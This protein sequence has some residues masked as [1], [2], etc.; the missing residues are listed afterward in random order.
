MFK[1]QDKK[2]LLA[3][4][5]KGEDSM[6][7]FKE[8][9]VALA[10]GETSFE[11]EAVAHTLDGEKIDIALSLSVPPGYEDTLSKVFVSMIDIT[12]E[13]A[14]DH[15]KSEF[16]SLVSHQ[17]RDPLGAI[18]WALEVLISEDFGR[19]SEGQ[20]KYVDE[21]HQDADRMTDL[22]NAYLNVSR[23]ELGTL[24]VE[25]EILNLK[26]IAEETIDE[27]EGKISGKKLK[28]SKKFTGDM[29]YKSD[30]KLIGIIFQNLLSN[31]VKYTPEG[32]KVGLTVSV[33]RELKIV[34]SD[35][36]CGIPKRQQS[37]V[38]D[39]LFRAKNARKVDPDGTGLGI[40]LVK[41]IVDHL[42]GKISFK[43]EEG[44]GSVFE[45]RL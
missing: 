8:E 31:V 1:A 14:V 33:G 20:K 3:G 11:D 4:L 42:G 5:P 27:L 12:K 19:L 26:S 23:L 30:V 40:Y 41:K 35:T 6:P 25:P 28:V 38:F 24:V 44:K 22:I 16:V 18:N 13:K 36:G 39:K 43:S 29:K 32:G 34:V 10:E 9:L 37:E 21:I 17:M 2:S 7:M 15:A 45:V